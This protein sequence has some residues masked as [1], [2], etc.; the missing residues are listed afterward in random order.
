MS[1]CSV[2]ATIARFHMSDG[3]DRHHTFNAEGATVD[4][5]EVDNE[6]YVR[7]RECRAIA[8]YN[9]HDEWCYDRCSACDYEW[10][11]DEPNYCPHCGARVRGGG[12]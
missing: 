6:R 5:I 2:N 11:E 8:I 3:R 7:V 12:E 4:W 9:M 1:D 10:Y